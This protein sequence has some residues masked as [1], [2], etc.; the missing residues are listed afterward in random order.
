MRLF[1]WLGGNQNYHTGLTYNIRVY[2]NPFLTFGIQQL[3][4]S[5][6]FALFIYLDSGCDLDHPLINFQWISLPILA[7]RMKFA[8]VS[9]EFTPQSV[10]F[11]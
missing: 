7:I 2:C 11:K 8:T 3:Y 9:L 10:H 4:R 1:V 5:E 6:E